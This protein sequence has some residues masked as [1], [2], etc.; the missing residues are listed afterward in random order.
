MTANYLLF[1]SIILFFC[2]TG[3]TLLSQHLDSSDYRTN[4]IRFLKP[5]LLLTI[6]ISVQENIEITSPSFVL[7]VLIGL[8]ISFLFPFQYHITHRGEPN[9]YSFPD[10]FS[11]G[12]FITD[13]LISLEI[14]FLSLLNHEL[15]AVLFTTIEFLLLIPSFFQ[16]LFFIYYHECIS[17]LAIK[18]LLDTNKLEVK[19]FIRMIPTSTKSLTA[20]LFTCI[21]I[22]M[23][24]INVATKPISKFSPLLIVISIATV[25]LLFVNKKALFRRTGLIT[26]YMQVKKHKEKLRNSKLSSST[27]PESDT[28]SS[29]LKDSSFGTILLVIGESAN[30]LHMKAFSDYQRETTP[31]LSEKAANKNFFLFPH[32]YSSWIQTPET[33]KMALTNINQYCKVKTDEEISI[34][35]I[36]NKT[37]FKTWWYSAQGFSE[38]KSSDVTVIAEA[39]QEKRWL[40]QDYS[41][42]QYDEKLLDYLK[43]IDNNQNNFVVIHLEGSHAEFQQRYPALFE[44][45]PYDKKDPYGSNSYDNSILY[46]DYIL[47]QI[48]DYF[49]EKLNLQAMLYFSDHGSLIGQKRKSSFSG[50][51]DTRIPFFVWLS[52]KYRNMYPQ[53]ANALRFH[54]QFYFTNDLIFDLLCGILQL[55]SPLHKPQYDI[56]SF[57]YQFTKDTLKTNLGKTTLGEDLYE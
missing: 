9:G 4:F 57:S 46:T 21:L 22:F 56:S 12:L 47:S 26:L 52:D 11:Y 30:R 42:R 15:F 45:W 31:W 6:I 43:N 17:E 2:F 49:I 24:K 39:A 23:Y 36:A 34:V 28:I 25:Y 48:F 32:A 16:L 41:V 7:A 38:E 14:I 35:N 29:P 10:D 19:E 55:D 37:G 3:I 50:F 1:S 18:A 54:E 51:E 20:I 53:T 33:V 40:M 27:Y 13:L 44:K 5:V 8:L